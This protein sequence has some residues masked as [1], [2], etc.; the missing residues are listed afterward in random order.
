VGGPARE[1]LHEL[2]I[3]CSVAEQE[4]EGGLSARVSPLAHVRSLRPASA[5]FAR[6]FGSNATVSV[7]SVTIASATRRFA[8][9]LG[10]EAGFT[11]GLAIGLTLTQTM[12]LLAEG[13][14]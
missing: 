1:T 4:R 12:L 8:S 3:A 7:C 6:R 2:R 9:R 5:R 13:P 11:L 14:M 10:E